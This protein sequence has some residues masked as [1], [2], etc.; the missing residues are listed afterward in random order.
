MNP[1]RKAAARKLASSA[2]E[3]GMAQMSGVVV[4]EPN[5]DWR[6]GSESLEAW[7]NAERGNEV[8]LILASL[9]DDRPVQP[10]SCRTCGRDYV[11]VECPTCRANRIR[12]RGRA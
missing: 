12:L 5:G 8:V 7:L 9:V 3:M 2:Y 10:R 1:L 11:E 4:Q 6:I